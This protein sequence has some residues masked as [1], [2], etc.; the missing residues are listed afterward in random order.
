MAFYRPESR[1]TR[2][3]HQTSYVLLLS[4][5]RVTRIRNLVERQV[6]LTGLLNEI[7]GRKERLVSVPVEPVDAGV[8]CESRAHLASLLSF[9]CCLSGG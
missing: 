8:E 3:D 6:A 2:P 4:G 9:T 1:K 7:N 5:V